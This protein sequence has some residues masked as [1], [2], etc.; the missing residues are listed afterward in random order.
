[1]NICIA[2]KNS[3][4]VDAVKYIL[5][6]NHISKDNLFVLPGPEDSGKDSWQPSLLKFATDNDLN[7]V[8][9]ESLY[10]IKD[11]KF[12]S[13]EY[14]QLIKPQLFESNHL[15]NIHFS[16]LPAYK[17]M[18][19]SAHPLLNGENSSGVTLHK[20]DSGID[21]GDIIS[22]QKFDINL[23]DTARD[24]YMKY[25]LFSLKL[26]KENFKNILNDNYS[27][28]PQEK[29]NSS[30]FSKKSIDYSNLKIDFKRTSF[31]IHNQIRAYIFKEYQ[32]PVIK[33]KKIKKTILLD[34]KIDTSVI[35]EEK[36]CF[37]ISGIDSYKIIAYKDED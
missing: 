34:E 6:D 12:F 21:T 19:T 37:V 27:T 1:M 10:N 11:L 7:V 25:L 33:N 3:I 29:I 28:V 31:E 35:I 15:V 24:L 8:K 23:N 32:L 16:L 4:A 26:I 9:I 22:Q 13:L 17:G 30:Y 14:S 2:G 36:D 20:I 5:E 18:Y